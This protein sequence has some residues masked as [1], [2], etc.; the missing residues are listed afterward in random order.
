MTPERLPRSPRTALASGLLAVALCA[1]ASGASA[2]PFRVIGPLPQLDLTPFGPIAITAPRGISDDGE[3][4]IGYGLIHVPNT[5]NPIVF[6][7]LPFRTRGAALELHPSPAPTEI[8][9]S[10]DGSTILSAGGPAIWVWDDAGSHVIDVSGQVQGL[11]N[12]IP[13]TD[14]SI[15]VGQADFAGFGTRAYR[16][17]NGVITRLVDPNGVNILFGASAVS[18]DGMIVTGQTQTNRTYRLDLDTNSLVVLSSLFAGSQIMQP[19]A[20]TPAGDVIV[21]LDA[22]GTSIQAFRWE[23]GVTV[24][25]G[26][27]PG[28]TTSF[29]SGVS[30]DGSVVVGGSD[31]FGLTFP[32]DAWIWDE[33]N[34]MR[35]LADVL[36]ARGVDLGGWHLWSAT[37]ISAD[38]RFVIGVAEDARL[39]TYAFVA[40]V[41]EPVAAA[42]LAVGVAFA[43]RRAQP[44][45][46]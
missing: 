25:L 40:R 27:L 36:A 38:G 4:V 24:G 39:D 23:N 35:A 19:S 45:R 43:V 42:L 7:Y 20:M 29:A 10:G 15:V 18:A 1:A 32:Q 33:A 28:H 26:A 13:N 44:P 12:A 34:G 6:E 8:T 9:V 11:S 22:K 3:V 41:P 14:A 21:G 46:V 2:A 30:A 16:M 37:G 17:E 5:T 31:P